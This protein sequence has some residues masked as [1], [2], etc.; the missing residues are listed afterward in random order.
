MMCIKEGWAVEKKIKI[1]K[2]HIHC[3]EPA[4]VEI[5][6]RNSVYWI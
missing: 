2:T 1:K 3:C 5:S 4:K 6:N